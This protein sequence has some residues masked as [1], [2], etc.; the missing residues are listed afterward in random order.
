MPGSAL[1]DAAFSEQSVLQAK[2]V[3]LGFDRCVALAAHRF[4]AFAIE[5]GDFGVCVA[6]DTR[7]LQMS[8]DNRDGRTRG[9]SL[10]GLV[11][12]RA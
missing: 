11:E 2:P 3:G 6:D 1:G 10:R 9:A 4:Q 7:L 12:S 5:N 8:R